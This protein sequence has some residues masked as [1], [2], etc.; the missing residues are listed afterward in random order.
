[1]QTQCSYTKSVHFIYG[2]HPVFLLS[3]RAAAAS[4]L[5]LFFSSCSLHAQWQHIP[6]DQSAICAG[7]RTSALCFSSTSVS[8]CPFRSVRLSPLLF[9]IFCISH[10]LSS[11][12]PSVRPRVRPPVLA[13]TPHVLLPLPL[14]RERGKGW[15]ENSRGRE[16]KRKKTHS[17]LLE[18]DG[19]WHWAAV[20]RGQTH[21]TGNSNNIDRVSLRSATS[22]SL[23]PQITNIYLFIY[24]LSGQYCT[25][26][27]TFLLQSQQDVFCV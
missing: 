21:H 6:L 17:R 20:C 8:F 19:A 12:S 9:Q 1:M 10:L 13:F 7:T 16:R 24:F 22:S 23:Q 5:E 26:V 4:R 3:I 15:R 27:H 11:T 25:I 14:P 2:T 18:A